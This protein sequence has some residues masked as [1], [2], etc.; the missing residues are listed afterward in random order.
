MATS[1]TRVCRTKSWPQCLP[2]SRA[3]NAAACW[4]STPEI[5]RRR[6]PSKR[7]FLYLLHFPLWK[8]SSTSATYL[9]GRLGPAQVCSLVADVQVLVSKWGWVGGLG[10]IP[11]SV[12][13]LWILFPW[14]TLS[15]LSGRSLI[16]Q[17]LDPGEGDSKGGLPFLRGEG[18]EGWMRGWMRE[19]WGWGS[20]YWDVKQ[21]HKLIKQT[22]SSTSTSLTSC[23]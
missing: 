1:S 3:V 22:N 12:A 10:A 11:E 17:W 16:L 19:G 6:D 18:E 15:G 7:L 8:T 21:I 13:F 2:S 5:P 20:C 4:T 9:Q 23:L 14:V